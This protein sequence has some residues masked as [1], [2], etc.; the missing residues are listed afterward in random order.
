MNRGQIH[1]IAA[2]P[3][4]SLHLETL[5]GTLERIKFE[6]KLHDRDLGDVL[7]KSK[8]RAEAARKGEA[9]ISAYSM[10]RGAAQ[11]GA[12]FLDPVLINA[13]L[14]SA[15]V[16]P[17][18][19]IAHAPRVLTA[20]LL[21]LIDAAAGDGVIDRAELLAAAPE[22]TE[23]GKVADMLRDALAGAHR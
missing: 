19:D 1:R 13:G 12:R 14:R 7:G 8:D 3:G 4:V 11:W 10:I 20:A 15:S 6:D 9:D 5:A 16:A 23:L 21:K 2:M 18:G 22:I 17:T